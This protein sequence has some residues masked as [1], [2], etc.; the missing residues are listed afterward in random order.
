MTRAA[1]KDCKISID[2]PKEEPPS[3]ARRNTRP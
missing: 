1:P 3:E 2:K